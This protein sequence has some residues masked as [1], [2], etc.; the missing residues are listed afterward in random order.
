[1]NPWDIV[2]IAAIII[3]VAL[4][5]IW[6]IKNRKQGKGCCGDCSRCGGCELTDKKQ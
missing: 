5:L 3:I 6:I 4:A 2:L 1:M